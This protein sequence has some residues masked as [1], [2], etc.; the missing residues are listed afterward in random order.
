M[1]VL[2]GNEHSHRQMALT[3]LILYLGENPC[4]ISCGVIPA[5]QQQ[6]GENVHLPEQKGKLSRSEIE[7][8]RV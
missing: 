3:K 1:N 7:L 8:N 5:C 4:R 6:L 2:M